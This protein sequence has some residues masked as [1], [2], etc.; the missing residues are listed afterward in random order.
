MARPT[1]GARTLRVR[2]AL[3]DT[4]ATE[5]PGFPPIHRTADGDRPRPEPGRFMVPMRAKNGVGPTPE[6]ERAAGILPAEEGVRFRAV[7]IFIDSRAMPLAAY[8]L[9]FLIK[10]GNAK[11]VGVEG[12]EHPAFKEAPFYD[13]KAIQQERVII[14]AFN[15]AS[16]DKLP[17]A[18]TRVATLHLQVS[19]QQA[20]EYAVRLESCAT[21]G[22]KKISSQTTFKEIEERKQ[23]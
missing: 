21:S 20:P 4:G 9:E 6:P 7:D 14:A 12:G 23:E 22:G 13:P 8:Q 5:F 18:R 15:T 1:T 17:K 16:A 10:S 19:G 3:A 2:S 11:V